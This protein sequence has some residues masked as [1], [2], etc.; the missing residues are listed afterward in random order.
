MYKTIE[1]EKSEV[2]KGYSDQQLRID[3]TQNEIEIDKRRS[4]KLI[5]YRLIEE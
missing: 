3:L 1:Y 4:S 5:F 2:Q